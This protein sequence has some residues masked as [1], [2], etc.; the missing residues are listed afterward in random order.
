MNKEPIRKL[1]FVSALKNTIFG[2][3]R[4][5]KLLLLTTVFLGIYSALAL[6]TNEFFGETVATVVIII[7]LVLTA[8][9]F[10]F[11]GQ[12]AKLEKG[13]RNFK[14]VLSRWKVDTVS[15]VKEISHETIDLM[16]GLLYLVI[17]LAII[18]AIILAFIFF[19]W[20]ISG[21]SATTIIIILLVLILLK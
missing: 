21:I 6:F 1:T 14:N 16:K 20:I 3:L 4:F 8:F 11:F 2:I 7:L 9:L 12:R 15:S 10:V 13:H 19:G 18:A 17:V 5:L